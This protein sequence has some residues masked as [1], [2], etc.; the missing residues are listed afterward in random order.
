M[1]C[2]IFLSEDASAGDTGRG[3]E[4]RFQ[5]FEPSAGNYKSGDRVPLSTF[6]NTDIDSDPGSST[7]KNFPRG[8]GSSCL[9]TEFERGSLT[10]CKKSSSFGA[11]FFQQA[12]GN[13]QLA[14]GNRSRMAEHL[15][16]KGF[17]PPYILLAFPESTPDSKP[18]F[19]RLQTRSSAS[20]ASSLV[21]TEDSSRCKIYTRVKLRQICGRQTDNMARRRPAVVVYGLRRLRLRP[22]RHGGD[23]PA[24][25]PCNCA[26]KA[27]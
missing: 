4:P 19:Q 18:Q 22:A 12:I 21:I 10:H 26:R 20:A 11:V 25:T 3:L 24:Q 5:H 13:W 9:L 1:V 7:V 27:R 23:Q 2:H 6:G 14:I 8:P 17:G 15:K 16:K